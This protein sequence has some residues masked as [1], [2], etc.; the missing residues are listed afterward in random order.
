MSNE[1][2]PGYVSRVGHELAIQQYDR[3]IKSIL[4]DD[5]AA[6]SGNVIKISSELV[7]IYADNK[8]LF[9]DIQ[10]QIL[11][12]VAKLEESHS[13][14]AQETASSIKEAVKQSMPQLRI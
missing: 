10:A 9:P 2:L 3:D 14:A 7:D 12:G 4:S 8:E 1:I 11:N 6:A 13:R 5:F